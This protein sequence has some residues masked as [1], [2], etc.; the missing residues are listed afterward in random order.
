[1]STEESMIPKF[2]AWHKNSKL[3]FP[4]VEM[5]WYNTGLKCHLKFQD[6]ILVCDENQIELMQWTGFK[7]KESIEIFEGDIL[8]Y[9]FGGG[10]DT[11]IIERSPDDNQL[12]ARYLYWSSCD[13]EYLAEMPLCASVIV[14]NRWANPELLEDRN[15]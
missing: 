5:I 13:T 7:D 12:Y 15:E 10:V 6:T 2:R 1:M 4:V 14:G 9:D 8:C 3:I 11:Y